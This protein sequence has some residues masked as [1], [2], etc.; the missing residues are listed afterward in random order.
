MKTPWKCVAALLNLFGDRPPPMFQLYLSVYIFHCTMSKLMARPIPLL[1]WPGKS[2][3]PS[4]RY[5]SVAMSY[6][7][8]AEGGYETF[9]TNSVPRSNFAYSATVKPRLLADYIGMKI[10]VLPPTQLVFTVIELTILHQ[11]FTNMSI[12]LDGV[13]PQY[14]FLFPL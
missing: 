5:I 9:F 11:N 10:S 6:L 12:V 1:N 14:F 13:S 8:W 3:V 2:I 4:A 7:L